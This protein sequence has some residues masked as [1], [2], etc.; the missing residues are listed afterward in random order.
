MNHKM[1][2]GRIAV[3]TVA[4]SLDRTA[5]DQLLRAKFPR[6]QVRCLWAVC[7]SCNLPDIYPLDAW[8]MSRANPSQALHCCLQ[9]SVVPVGSSG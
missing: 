2:Q 3:I 8:M 1:P 6:L 4:E 7:V 5:L 9:D